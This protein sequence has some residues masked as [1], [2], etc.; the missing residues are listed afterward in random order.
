MAKQSLRRT[1]PAARASRLML[2]LLL[3]PFMQAGHRLLL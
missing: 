2:L 3:L 1:L